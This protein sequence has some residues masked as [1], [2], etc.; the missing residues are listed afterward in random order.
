MTTLIV[1]LLLTAGF[2]WV[3]WAGP[4]PFTN[5]SFFPLWFGYILTVDGLVQVRGGRS[6]MRRAP[7]HFAMLFLLS[8]PLWWTFEALNLTVKNWSYLGKEIFDPVAAAVWSTVAFSTVIPAILETAEL[9]ASFHLRWRLASVPGWI[10]ARWNWT[11]SIAAGL[12]GFGL[13]V[14]APDIFFPLVWVFPFL[15]FD[16][17]NLR[18]GSESLLHDASS[19]R[20]SRLAILA[21]AGLIC[22]FFWEMWNINSFPKWEYAVPVVGF[23]KVFEMPVLGYGGYVPFA[24][25][26]YSFYVLANR[27]VGLSPRATLVGVARYVRSV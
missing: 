19:G 18:L 5:V 26:V 3:A 15:I 4:A 16:G 1:G 24:W 21:V 17:I 23:W 10:S 9:V 25:S 7:L 11:A 2:W 14:A 12:V 6:L 22:G 8:A 13:V 20:L 27:I